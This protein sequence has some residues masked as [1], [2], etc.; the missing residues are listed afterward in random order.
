MD[1]LFRFLLRNLLRR[2]PSS[3]SLHAFYVH[4]FTHSSLPDLFSFLITPLVSQRLVIIPALS[5]FAPLSP[6]LLQLYTLGAPAVALDSHDRIEFP[7]QCTR[8]HAR[9]QPR[10]FQFLLPRDTPDRGPPPPPPCTSTAV[11]ASGAAGSGS[12]PQPVAFKGW[13]GAWSA[14]ERDR[15]QR[16]ISFFGVFRTQRVRTEAHLVRRSL[17][18]VD[19][20]CRCMLRQMLTH[21]EEVRM[22]LRICFV[23]FLVY[24]YFSRPFSNLSDF[25]WLAIVGLCKSVSS[26][27]EWFSMQLC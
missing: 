27:P 14:S 12:I 11:T 9:D 4:I 5:S 24:F 6:P 23:C 10:A 21:A 25:R 13:T 26:L 18:E 8:P 3:W 19:L 17:H 2:L 15:L 7:C 1:I 20:Y 22:G 16:A